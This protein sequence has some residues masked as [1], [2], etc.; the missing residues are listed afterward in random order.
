MAIYLS[1]CFSGPRRWAQFIFGVLG[2]LLICTAHATVPIPS[3]QILPT[4]PGT[5][6]EDRDVPFL[7]WYEDLTPQ[8]YLE[9]E[10]LMSGTANV[11]VY[12]SMT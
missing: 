10:I 12:V 8:G 6:P 9:E 3:A 4:S 2:V 7:A 5:G 1:R 11:Y